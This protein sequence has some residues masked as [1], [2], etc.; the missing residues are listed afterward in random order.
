[1]TQVYINGEQVTPETDWSRYTMNS[2]EM[3]RLVA[4]IEKRV[5]AAFNGNG[6]K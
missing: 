1:M 6:G 2:P 5:N 3:E 4:A